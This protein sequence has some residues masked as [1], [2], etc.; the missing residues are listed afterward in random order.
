MVVVDGRRLLSHRAPRSTS[1]SSRTRRERLRVG[2]CHRRRVG[3]A[4]RE[5]SFS[6]RARA[7]RVV[8]RGRHSARADDHDSIGLLSLLRVFFLWQGR[9]AAAHAVHQAQ[10]VMGGRHLLA[11]RPVVQ[12]RDGVARDNPHG[13]RLESRGLHDSIGARGVRQNP[14]S[15][16]FK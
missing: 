9:A 13:L 5:R 7:P 8:R 14:T 1:P 6:R 15:Q 4:G 10:I 11:K 3:S 12:C 16:D 2:G